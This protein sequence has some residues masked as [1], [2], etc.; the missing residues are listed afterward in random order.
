MTQTP[1]ASSL[2]FSESDR[3]KLLKEH[4]TMSAEIHFLVKN[5]AIIE[6]YYMLNKLDNLK[7]GALINMMY[8]V[9]ILSR[10]LSSSLS[11]LTVARK[12][13]AETYGTFSDINIDSL[14]ENTLFMLNEIRDNA[15]KIK[16]LGGY[17]TINKAIQYCEVLC[18]K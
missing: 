4:P 14:V 10:Q 6:A 3:R 8:E 7:A 2:T 9:Q 18:N 16:V 12:L 15:F 5:C 11:P 1:I 17:Y 13:V